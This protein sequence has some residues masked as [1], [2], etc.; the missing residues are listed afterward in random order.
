MGFDADTQPRIDEVE[1]F[2]RDCSYLIDGRLA[3]YGYPYP[4]NAALGATLGTAAVAAVLGQI[5][6]WCA[7]GAA[8]RA[9]MAVEQVV[10]DPGQ[11]TQGQLYW[12]QF[13]AWLYGTA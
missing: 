9:S 12:A 7:V 8:G 10:R 13:W 6:P 4:F 11:R 2:D 5:R 3:W 1:G